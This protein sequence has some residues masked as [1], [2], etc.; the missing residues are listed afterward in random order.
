[1]N[2]GALILRRIDTLNRD[3][4]KDSKANEDVIRNAATKAT[5]QENEAVINANLKTALAANASVFGL[6]SAT[7]R[8][9]MDG[10]K[11]YLNLANRITGTVPAKE[12]AK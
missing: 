6:Q 2:A 9:L 1:M 5:N 7:T 8:I 3:F 10:L 11:A 4:E 12:E